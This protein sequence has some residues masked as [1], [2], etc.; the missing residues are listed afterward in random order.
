MDYQKFTHVF[1]CIHSGPLEQVT[2]E[3]NGMNLL[4]D[5]K[6]TEIEGSEGTRM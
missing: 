4:G 3:W 5:D 2:Y 6:K 1:E